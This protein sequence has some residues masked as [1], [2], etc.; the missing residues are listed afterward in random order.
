MDLIVKK[1]KK[2]K[3]IFKEKDIPKAL[4]YEEYDGK[5][6]YYKG[7]REVMQGLTTIQTVMGQ[8]D[9]QTILVGVILEFLHNQIDKNSYFA[10]SNEAGF[11]LQKKMNIASDIV[12]YDKKILQQYQAKGKYL[13]IPPL[14]IIEIDIQGDTKEF[15]VTELDYY[16]M[17]TKNLLDFGVQEVIWFFSHI[18]KV[19]VAKP[20]EN[21]QIMDWDKD[22]LILSQYKINLEQE[23]KQQG[24]QL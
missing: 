10:S 14:S 24:W 19:F 22:V 21:W 13:E 8:S 7:F 1:T 11:H 4:I 15:G 23:L 2:P 3:T 6:L 18:R 20:N 5:P 17:K 16:S 9:I 12:I